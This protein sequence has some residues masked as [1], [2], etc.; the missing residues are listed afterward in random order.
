[1]AARTPSGISKCPRSLSSVQALQGP[2]EYARSL[3]LD[4]LL[5]LAVGLDTE[6]GKETTFTRL[7]RPSS[8]S[9]ILGRSF[10]AQRILAPGMTV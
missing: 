6:L 7:K 2:V 8:A 10:I 3:A 1:M 9:R 5:D 4:R